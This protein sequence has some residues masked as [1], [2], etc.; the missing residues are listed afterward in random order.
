VK[1]KKKKKDTNECIYKTEIDENRL[2]VN[3][4]ERGGSKIILGG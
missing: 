1:S 4:G 2:M 3:K